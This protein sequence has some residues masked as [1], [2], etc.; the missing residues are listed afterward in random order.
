[1]RA[2]FNNAKNGRTTNM[3]TSSTVVGIEDLV[4]QLHTRYVL[5]RDT[6][7]GYYYEIDDTYSTN[8]NKLGNDLTI[9]LYEVDSL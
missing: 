4:N 3:M 8:V 5:K 2:E 6:T 1:M 7:I 9:N